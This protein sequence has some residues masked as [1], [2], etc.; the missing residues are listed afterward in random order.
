MGQRGP[1]PKPF[2]MKVLE[3]NPG[4]RPLSI[5]GVWRPFVEI[6]DPPK[7]LGKQALKEWKRITVELAANNLIAKLDRD[8]LAVLCQSIERVTLFETSLKKRMDGLLAK[9]IDPAEAYLTK[10]GS[11]YE[12]ISGLYVALN[13][14][15]DVLEKLLAEFGMSPAQRSRVSLGQRGAQLQLFDGG[16][17]A[18]PDANTPKKPASFAD[19]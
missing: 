15:R 12:A 1:K 19:F 14:E 6:P 8:M 17:T 10:S 2:E 4:K 3:G 11:G 9:G 16:K 7:Y 5:D 13:K 18:Q